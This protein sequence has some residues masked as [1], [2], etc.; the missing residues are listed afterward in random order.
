MSRVRRGRRRDPIEQAMELALKL[1]DFIGYGA[2]W[3][4]VSRLE[5]VERDIAELLSAEPAR[6]I[7]L[8]ETFVAGCY[9]KAE[10]AR[11]LKPSRL[12]STAP[13][14]ERGVGLDEEDQET[15]AVRKIFSGVYQMSWIRALA[16]QGPP[17]CRQSSTI[18]R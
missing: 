1:G 2:S 12:S 8:Y 11:S 18:S 6:A 14:V 13:S 17:H 5:E 16:S 4:F 9:E 7:D 15:T 10:E 3:E